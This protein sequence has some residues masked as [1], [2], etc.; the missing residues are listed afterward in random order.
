MANYNKTLRAKNLNG[1]SGV[2]RIVAAIVLHDTAGSGTDGDVKYLVNDPEKR[3]ISVDFVVT[4]DGTIWQIN[5]DPSCFW[6]NHAGRSTKLVTRNQGTFTGKAV[7][8]HTVG[9]EISQKAVMTGLNP[10][11]PA[12]QV[13]AV[14]DLCRDLMT[15]FDLKKEDITTHAKIITDGS[16]SDPRNFP[17]LAFWDSL[18]GKTH[19]DPEPA[20]VTPETVGTF[21]T[22]LQGETLWGLANQYDTTIEAIKALNHMNGRSD[23]IVVGQSLLVKE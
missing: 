15:Q 4:K 20:E 19:V 1:H 18:D 12:E 17:W 23:T 7:N 10:A 16:R 22:V 6:T 5:P 8:S 2:K 3:K 13:N 21:H 14:A 11:Y 9:I